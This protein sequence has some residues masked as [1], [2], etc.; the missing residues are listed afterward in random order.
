MAQIMFPVFDTNDPETRTPVALMTIIVHW[1]QYFRHILPKSIK[2]ITVVLANSC[3]GPY[4]FQLD[5]SEAVGIGMGDHHDSEFDEWEKGSAFTTNLIE[6]GTLSKLEM[7]TLGCV[8][9][10]KAYPTNQFKNE[11]I[12]RSP[13]V[14]TVAIIGVFLFAAFM[15]VF[16]D[17]LVERRQKLV[18]AKAT[19]S[20]GKL[21][22]SFHC[23]LSSFSRT[24]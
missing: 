5:G 8:Y 4:T 21:K 17:R 9:T 19:Q 14:I 6:D 24:E 22:T 18:L 13:V 11:Y 15:F 10:V 2:G 3:D 7:S 20:T 1:R 16:Y 12:T 23:L